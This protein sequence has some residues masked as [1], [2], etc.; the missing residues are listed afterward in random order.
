MNCIL[1]SLSLSAE[2]NA[3][4][5]AFIGTFIVAIISIHQNWLTGKDN[6]K[7]LQRI[8]IIEKRQVIENKLN[9]F[10]IPL[11]HH[12]EHSK[13]LFKIFVKDKPQNFRTLTY[14]L[15]KNQIYGSNNVQVVL[16]KNDKSLIK[17]IIKVGTKIENLIHE[18]SYLIGDDIEFVQ[19][20]TP[21][22]EY[23]HITYERDMTLLSL[24]ISHLITIRMAF[25]EDLSGQINKFEGFVFPNE[26]NVRV[27]EKINELERKINSYDLEI[28]KLNK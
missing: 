1:L 23:A 25:N 6:K 20:Y 27:N 8:A 4:L 12:L 5:I 10:Y 3:A 28:L 7:N 17:T 9:Q 19:N 2:V 18:K 26:V 24:L 11:R 22:T 21:R 13:T 15:D 14:L 16:N